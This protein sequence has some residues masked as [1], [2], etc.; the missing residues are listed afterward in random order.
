M[1]AETN[2]FCR[3]WADNLREISREVA[4]PFKIRALIEQRKLSVR[5]LIYSIKFWKKKKKDCR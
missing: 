1:Y 5:A 2:E 4:D 3:E